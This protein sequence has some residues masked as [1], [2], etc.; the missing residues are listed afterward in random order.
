[1]LS[2]KPAFSLSSITFIERLFSSFSLSAIRV[3]SS[4]Y[5]R[6]LTFLPGILI[7]A[8]NNTCSQTIMRITDSENKV[9][10]Q[11]ELCKGSSYGHSQYSRVTDDLA[12]G[13]LFHIF[14]LLH[15]VQ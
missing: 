15:L 14:G 6:L 13:N 8:Y 7:P 3:V 5:L 10:N 4:A 12:L 1:M 2:F 9:T 11:H